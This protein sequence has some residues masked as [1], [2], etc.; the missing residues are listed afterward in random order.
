MRL[1]LPRMKERKWGR[2]INVASA[3]G[4]VASKNKGAYVAAKHGIV[5]LNKG[6]ISFV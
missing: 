2:V 6:N 4:L 5:G 3:H 1:L